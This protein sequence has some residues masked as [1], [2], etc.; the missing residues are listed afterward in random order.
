VNE[1]AHAAS[2]PLMLPFAP[3]VSPDGTRHLSVHVVD[4]A[5]RCGE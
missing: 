4:R 1:N 2:V 5:A 3:I